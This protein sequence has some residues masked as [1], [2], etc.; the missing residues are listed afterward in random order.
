MN[1]RDLNP[2]IRAALVRWQHEADLQA[3]QWF[4][5]EIRRAIRS[6][7]L[8]PAVRNAQWHNFGKRPPLAGGA[9]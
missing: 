2:H 1:F 6:G 5:H 7:T 3:E 4:A 8:T 9:T